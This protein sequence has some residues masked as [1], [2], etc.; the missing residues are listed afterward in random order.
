MFAV[1]GNQFPT[2]MEFLLSVGIGLFIASTA[3]PALF[4]V[5]AAS[6]LALTWPTMWIIVVGLVAVIPVT[7]VVVFVLSTC[8]FRW[9]R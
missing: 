2:L 3:C 7:A 9:A 6:W 1:L 4:L 8:L 5:T